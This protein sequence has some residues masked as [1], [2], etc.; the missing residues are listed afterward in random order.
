[1]GKTMVFGLSQIIKNI[2]LKRSTN[3]RRSQTYSLSLEGLSDQF[4][5]TGAC[6]TTWRQ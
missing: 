5:I 4:V 1:M 6:L 2:R 3:C